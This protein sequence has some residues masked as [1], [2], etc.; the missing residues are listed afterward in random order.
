MKKI[1]HFNTNSGILKKGGV[2]HFMANIK[3]AQKKVRK[4]KARTKRNNTYRSSIDK[5]IKTIGKS[6]DKA[7]IGALIQKAFSLIDKA[8]KTKV[9]HK[10]KAARLKS[11]VSRLSRT[12]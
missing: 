4:D 1:F 6:K 11:R 10:N 5:S 12:A 7:G 3:S 9:I 8:A 2:I